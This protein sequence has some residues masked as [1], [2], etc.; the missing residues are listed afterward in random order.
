MVGALLAGLI[1]IFANAEAT[2]FEVF[3]GEVPSEKVQIFLMGEVHTEIDHILLQEEILN[4]FASDGD[5]LFV[6]GYSALPTVENWNDY[7]GRLRIHSLPLLGG[8]DDISAYHDTV[9]SYGMQLKR[10]DCLNDSKV[11]KSEKL[12]INSDII[13][14][15]GQLNKYFLQRNANM[16]NIVRTY[17]GGARKLFLIAGMRHLTG[18]Q[19]VVETL[20]NLKV[21]YSILIPTATASSL[22][23]LKSNDYARKLTKVS[24]SEVCQLVN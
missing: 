15:R 10:L 7:Q 4:R 19:T 11:S 13:S 22:A 1:S 2:K 8:W 21:R 12:R 18:D 14:T 5:L 24:K 9:Y 17:G 16:M 20:E 3:A 6:E 23:A